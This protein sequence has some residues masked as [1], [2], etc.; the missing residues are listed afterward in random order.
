LITGH[1]LTL[2]AGAADVSAAP[3]VPGDYQVA[4]T[5]FAGQTLAVTPGRIQRD[6]TGRHPD[7][8]LTATRNL[9]VSSTGLWTPPALR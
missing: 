8:P 1:D 2:S 5:S 7:Q 9:M 3:V 4:G 6:R